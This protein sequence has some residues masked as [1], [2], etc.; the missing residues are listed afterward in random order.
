MVLLRLFALIICAVALTSAFVP[1]NYD[2]AVSAKWQP[3][4]KAELIAFAKALPARKLTASQIL[5]AFH[6]LSAKGKKVAEKGQKFMTMANDLANSEKMAKD[7]TALVILEEEMGPDKMDKMV[8]KE[9]EIDCDRVRGTFTFDGVEFRAPSGECN[10][11]QRPRWGASE[12]PLLRLLR[13]DYGGFGFDDPTAVCFGKLLPGARAISVGYHGD[14][15]NNDVDHSYFLMQW[16]Q[17][18]DH[19]V[20]LAPTVGGVDC[21]D[22]NVQ[23][24]NPN[25]LSIKVADNDPQFGVNAGIFRRKFI[26]LTRSAPTEEHEHGGLFQPREQFNEITAYIDASNVYGSDDAR[27]E[28]LRDP[29]DP[30]LLLTAPD[31][32]GK[33]FLP[34][35]IEGIP[36]EV[37][38]GS[39][40]VCHLAGDVRASEQTFLTITHATFM[41]EHNRI[42][43]IL[44]KLQPNWSDDRLFFETRK[45]VA[46]VFQHI[47]YDEYLPNLLN[48][49]L[50]SQVF[51]FYIGYNPLVNGGILNGFAAAAFRLGHSQLRNQLARLDKDYNLISEI[52]F[53]Q[54]FFQPHRILE[55]PAGK[56]DNYVRGLLDRQSQQI[57]RFVSE[58][59]NNHLFEQ[60]DDNNQPSGPGLDLA[61]LNIQR[62]RDH[63]LPRYFE[64]YKL[65]VNFAN[66]HGLRVPFPL[67]SFADKKLLRNIYGTIRCVDLWVGGLSEIALENGLPVSKQDGGQLGPTLFFIVSVQFL[68]LRDGDR[69]FYKNPVVNPG[70]LIPRPVLTPAQI[71]AID[72]TSLSTYICNNVNDPSTMEVQPQ[73]FRFPRKTGDGRVA[74]L[75]DENNQ[76]RPC[77]EILTMPR[78]RCLDLKPWVYCE[79]EW[80]PYFC[81]LFKLL[82]GCSSGNFFDTHFGI[83]D[84]R[85]R[86]TCNSCTVNS[87]RRDGRI[88]SLEDIK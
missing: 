71:K 52:N 79:D 63:G 43:L 68:I 54:A 41:L 48:R 82:G 42:V 9:E 57:D 32:Q 55:D 74:R 16:G 5:S 17:F 29:D 24:T 47:V 73:A 7:G 22:E 69:F 36:N 62:G 25:C 13:P 37:C 4:T 20:T 10:N 45:I 26:P 80:S 58:E 53:R 88:C 70:S 50:F 83:R 33:P 77:A 3:K 49:H 44:R 6:R 2:E 23:A 34:L 1:K 75:I 66:K 27:L 19:D 72:D 12:A 46:S 8:T 56:F 30:A 28:V 31:G 86:A 87:K 65:A 11:I 78:T 85:C 81:K 21:S 15:A 39:V 60:V 76:R 61:S 67:I 14:R 35:S 84:R 59:L 64:F 40:P 38:Q 51:G 18:L